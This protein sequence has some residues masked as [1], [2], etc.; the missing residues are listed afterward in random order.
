MS[1]DLI[2]KLILEYFD[3]NTGDTIENH[4][5]YINIRSDIKISRRSIKHIV[6]QRKVDK[7]NKLEI[8][9]IFENLYL[10]IDNNNYEFVVNKKEYSSIII[11]EKNILNPISLVI[12]TDSKDNLLEVKTGFYRASGK[13]KKLK[14]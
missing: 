2:K 5:E 10:N 11:L 3:L 8:I 4:N 9:S 6:E 12:V 1:L 13:I 7:Y 14:K